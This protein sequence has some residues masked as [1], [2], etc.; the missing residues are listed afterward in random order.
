MLEL[1]PIA[2]R[3]V[4][5]S[6]WLRDKA[7]DKI[8]NVFPIVSNKYTVKLKKINMR[9]KT[10]S[11]TEQKEALLGGK[12]LVNPVHVDLEVIDNKTNTVVKKLN[13]FKIADIPFLTSRLTMIVKGNDY[14]LAN[15]IRLKPGIYTRQRENNVVE[16]MVNLSKG[17]NFRIS[18]DP[19]DGV[20]NMEVGTK[21]TPLYPLLNGMGVS[22]DELNNAWGKEI[23]MRNKNKVRNP[24]IA[25]TKIYG[26]FFPLKPGD[27]KTLTSTDKVNRLNKYFY[28]KTEMDPVVNKST[29]G[30]GA[31]KVTPMAIL[32]AT[33]KIVN[34]SRGDE[35]TDDR[36]NLKHQVV[37]SIDD[38]ISENIEKTTPEVVNKIKY[39][40]DNLPAG[41]D[42]ESALPKNV[43]GR[44]IKKFIT[45]TP[46][47]APLPQINPLDIMGSAY[48]ITQMGPGGIKDIRMVRDDTR[49]VNSSHMGLIDPI[50][51]KEN[52]KAGVNLYTTPSAMRD[53]KGD[54][55]TKIRNV[56]TGKNEVLSVSKIAENY[57]AFPGQD[58][59]PS[60][61]QVEAMYQGKVVR[62]PSSKIK[63]QYDSPA[64]LFSAGTNLLP[65]LNSMAGGRALMA[66]K[67]LDHA[68]PLKYREQP[69]IQTA[70]NTPFKT[71]E[72][73]VASAFLPKARED[74]VVHR[75]TKDEI[76]VKTEDGKIYKDRYETN[77][78]LNQ[79]TYLHTTLNVKKGDKVRKNQML[80]DSIY[81]KD[82][83]FAIGK[84]LEA[85]Y[86]DYKGLNVNDG[87]VVSESAAKKLT[88]LHMNKGEYLTDDNHLVSRSKFTT[89]F[90]NKFDINQLSNISD[91]GVVKEGTI[92]NEGD[93]IVLGIEKTELSA[94][95]SLLGNLSKKLYKPYREDS[96]VWEHPFPGTVTDVRVGG[97]R[98]AFQITSEQPAIIGDKISHRS[99]SKGVITAIVK[100]D[101]MLRNEEG[102]P[103]DIL[104]SPTSI[105]SR[106]NPAQ[107][108]EMGLAKVSKKIG[109][110]IVVDNF[111][112]KDNHKFVQDVMKRYK[113]KDKED[114]FDPV[115]NKTIKNV[116][117]GPIYVM[118][119]AS[120]AEKA[121]GVRDFGSY[122][123]NERPSKG[124]EQG[125]KGIGM[126][127]ANSLLSHN[128]RANLQEISTLKGNKNKEFWDA[129]QRGLPLPSLKTPF[130]YDKLLGMMQA[131]GIKIN[132]EDNKLIA[133]PLTDRDISQFSS[134]EITS[135]YTV[136]AKDLRPEKDGLFDLN[137]TGGMHG[138]KWGHITL[139]EP[140][141]N[142][143]MKKPVQI[144]LGETKKS[145]DERIK[146]EGVKAIEK[147]LSKIDIDKR[148]DDLKKE[149]PRLAYSDLDKA[150]KELKYLKSLKKNNMTP[151]QA[152]ILNKVPV[153][154]PIMR[155]I[156]KMSGSNDL[157]VS[158]LNRLYSDVIHNN[159]AIKMLK[160]QVSNSD[161]GPM[162]STL[163]QS[164]DAL[165]GVGESPNVKIQKQGLKGILTTVSGD[166]PKTGYFQSKVFSKTQDL[167]SR[168]VIVPNPRMGIDDVGIPEDTL[169]GL[170]KPMIVR[171]LVNR[172]Y[173]SVKAIEMVR[174]KTEV[175]RN[176]LL[177]EA[178]TRPVF[179]NRAPS[180]HKH[181]V[182]AANPIPVMGKSI[183]LSPFAEK[184]LGA[185]FDGDAVQVHV[186]IGYK[187][188]MEAQDMKLSKML[189]TETKKQNNLIAKPEQDT[190][191]GI[192]KGVNA[193]ASGKT[194]NFK[195]YDEVKRAYKRGE[196][197]LNDKVNITK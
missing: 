182:V 131:S 181:S 98:V 134:G 50:A 117:S 152:Y 83:S 75:I 73:L 135:P 132:K 88:S 49:Q 168:G 129:Y 125:A 94:E 53:Q 116:K 183:Q 100:D 21:K 67:H 8:K 30:L 158:S 147:D 47:A 11:I 188:V 81:S 151:N 146:N 136:R 43:F 13:S 145:L 189:F 148:I 85:A 192:H 42:I 166:T 177:D 159:Q 179:I 124:G 5:R 35:V 123:A 23:T 172:G 113:V 18:M 176:E 86:L 127:A 143:I 77:F 161:L 174:D 197:G 112:L 55:Y 97:S 63:Y 44:S 59:S 165:V 163:Q 51:T 140:V 93:P 187:A 74:G 139:K 164:V 194:F 62:V 33:K 39:K 82:G 27:A 121:F 173:P 137:V 142:P 36:D 16:S 46:I 89:L 170:Y 157:Q 180:L 40:L 115:N 72:K 184:G 120:Q 169:W 87:V 15:Q 96:I 22:D 56:K 20:F 156:V 102:K 58:L 14:G 99:A 25:L 171:R 76:Q 90:P 160:G 101:D 91:N 80:G 2:A 84:N 9:D 60:N 126:L 190:N 175:A 196:I 122:D 41:R 108:L 70:S 10:F 155:P 119:Q 24:D 178:K 61:R 133:A 92:L 66:K 153:L 109:K 71:Q 4:D 107:L 111:A 31:S 154:P 52:E 38:S 95:Q 7:I 79:R 29:I 141:I 68:L 185:D 69:L 17:K 65:F 150:V 144:M 48:E 32:N 12:T 186:P 57:I 193:K 195:N 118:K 37:R 64:N 103:V 54:F 19:Q 1:Q 138:K 28:E 45:T 162:R 26:S 3:S 110:P 105:I 104:F 130:A 6:K 191:Y 34:V 106:Q 149:M 128:A 167:S 114:I 78:P